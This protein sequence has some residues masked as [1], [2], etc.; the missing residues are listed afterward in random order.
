MSNAEAANLLGFF[1]VALLLGAFF[2]N[3]FGLA[4]ADRHPYLFLNFAGAGLACYSSYLIGFM[5]FVLLEGLW[6]A[7]AAAG[8]AR[9]LIEAASARG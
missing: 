1:G 2:L 4:R 6:A 8:M 3:L 5:P 7:V 9:R